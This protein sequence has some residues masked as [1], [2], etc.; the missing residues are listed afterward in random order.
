MSL[1]WR[2]F[3]ALKRSGLLNWK[4]RLWPAMARAWWHCGPGFPLLL[5]LAALRSPEGMAVLDDEG[6]LSFSELAYNVEALSIHLHFRE[7]LSAGDR[8]ALQCSN[9]RRFIIGLAAIT[10]LGADCLP[11]SP[12]LPQSR[13]NELLSG[14]GVTRILS[15]RELETEAHTLSWAAPNV[16][17]A[18]LPR[19]S[20]P[21]Q[22][23]VLTSG[24]TGASKGIKRK[25]SLRQVL[26]VTA[27][28]LEG[29]PLK[30]GRPIVLAIPLY[31]GYGIATLAMSLA[32]QA[33]LVV[34]RRYEIAP[35]MTKIEEAESPLLVTVPTLLLRWLREAPRS[36]RLAAIVT[37]SA[38][39]DKDLCSEVLGRFG[40][41][42][43]NLYGSTETGVI[44]M[45]GPEALGCS[46]GSVGKPL[47]GNEVRIVDPSNVLTSS[48]TPGEILVRGPLVLGPGPDGWRRTGDLG[49]WDQAGHLHICGRTDSMIISGGEN[50][51]PYE[52]EQALLA[53]Q[54]IEECAVL[55]APDQE[56]GHRLVAA[57]V[58]S[59]PSTLDE[60]SL[61]NWLEPR[62][63]RHKRPRSIHFLE[64]IPRNPL[65]KVD[66]QRLRSNLG[67]PERTCDEH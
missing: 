37:G 16:P 17:T 22:L 45:A 7:N 20:R 42:L 13:L 30:P 62:L 55:V 5:S 49:Y 59:S 52:L 3:L 33:P 67:L 47:P 1:L 8:V 40:P 46:P 44:A 34:G 64:G 36:A 29:L 12:T 50:V 18:T 19:C 60:A 66:Q 15:D 23:I 63:E 27:G 24:T 38:P 48:G 51:F 56:F 32:L 43:V 28:L 57:V 25:P 26:P 4:L 2:V 11:L 31:H 65:G 9:G 39:L 41:I 61:R 10:R 14:Q 58:R 54:E 53:H 21:G 6:E 35:L